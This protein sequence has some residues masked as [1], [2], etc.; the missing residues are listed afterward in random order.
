VAEPAPTKRFTIVRT[1]EEA[2]LIA[3]ALESAGIHAHVIDKTFHAEPIPMSRLFN[4]VEIHVAAEQF[5]A[6]GKVL[7][8]MEKLERRCPQCGALLAP[9][10]LNCE[11]CGE[12]PPAA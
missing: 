4:R 11:A 9:D 3:G 10:E 6:A 1:M 7:A 8:E 12:P 2:T 5:E